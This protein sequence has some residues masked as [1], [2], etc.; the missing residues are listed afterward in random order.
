M[1]ESLDNFALDMTDVSSFSN[2]MEY[3]QNY[4]SEWKQL[5]NWV[6]PLEN[7]CYKVKCILCNKEYTADIGVIKRHVMSLK[8]LKCENYDEIFENLDF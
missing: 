8:H 6:E 3:K 5:Y 7:N 2:L 4:K 1:D